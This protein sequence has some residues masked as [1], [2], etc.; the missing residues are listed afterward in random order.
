LVLLALV[1]CGKVEENVDGEIDS[2]NIEV[3]MWDDLNSA[4]TEENILEDEMNIEVLSEDLDA[5]VSIWEDWSVN[6]D[7]WTDSE[8][9]WSDWSVNIDAW[10]GSASVWSDLGIDVNLEGLDVEIK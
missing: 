6:V 1:S 4:D 10:T 5:S 9:V 7:T 3:N 2:N 8:S